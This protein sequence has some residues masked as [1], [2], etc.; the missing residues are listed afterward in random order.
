MYKTQKMFFYDD[1]AN[2]WKEATILNNLIIE[3]RKRDL[4]INIKILL[5]KILF[6]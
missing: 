2:Y 5:G 3:A 1:E 6:K 4:Q